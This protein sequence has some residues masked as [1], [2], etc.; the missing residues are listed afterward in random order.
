MV[1][2]T[3]ILLKYVPEWYHLQKSSSSFFKKQS[4]F[5]MTRFYRNIGWSQ[6][7]N[8]MNRFHYFL[9]GE[10]FWDSKLSQHKRDINRSRIAAACEEHN[11]SYHF[12]VST[13][14]KLNINLNLYS[15]SR[16]AVYEP[17]TFKSLVEICK[18]AT[19]EK[20]EPAN[21]TANKL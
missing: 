13:L 12:L 4:L 17:K 18:S 11:Y 15:L 7:K 10:M 21:F 2:T 5:H 14:P 16:L 9:Q 1:R 8:A 19:E 20:L 3:Q 6:H